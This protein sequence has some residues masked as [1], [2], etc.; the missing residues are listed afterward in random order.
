MTNTPI[1]PSSSGV[2]HVSPSSS[3]AATPVKGSPVQDIAL[4]KLK[5][6][7]VDGPKNLKSKSVS[8]KTKDVGI[9]KKFFNRRFS[10]I[11]ET[12][13]QQAKN[14]KIQI[15]HVEQE[16]NKVEVQTRKVD[17]ARQT[18]S[19]E[20]PTDESIE[21]HMNYF[22]SVPDILEQ[23]KVQLEEL[24]EQ[25][26]TANELA[27]EHV[28]FDD[29]P[30]RILELRTKVEHLEAKLELSHAL[31][32][33]EIAMKDYYLDKSWDNFTKVQDKRAALKEKLQEIFDENDSLTRINDVKQFLGKESWNGSDTYQLIQSAFPS[34]KGQIERLLNCTL[35]MNNEKIE[36]LE[37]KAANLKESISEYHVLSKRINNIEGWLYNDSIFGK[38][39]RI[40]HSPAS[41]K[42]RLQQ[43][44]NEQQ[45]IYQ[46]IKDNAHI[47]SDELMW[48]EKVVQLNPEKASLRKDLQRCAQQLPKIRMMQ[49]MS[50]GMGKIVNQLQIYINA[51]FVDLKKHK[52]IIVDEMQKLAHNVRNQIFLPEDLTDVKV[53]DQVQTVIASSYP[54]LRERTKL[55]F[56]L[57]KEAKLRTELNKAVIAEFAKQ[58]KPLE[59]DTEDSTEEGTEEGGGAPPEA[60]PLTPVPSDTDNDL[61][62]E[63]TKPS[64]GFLAHLK[65]AKLKKGTSKFTGIVKH[66]SDILSQIKQGKGLKKA[67][68]P[69][70]S[71]PQDHPHLAAIKAGVA[72]KKGEAPAT[73]EIP[74]FQRLFKELQEGTRT[75]KDVTKDELAQLT[76]MERSSLGIAALRKN[77]KDDDE[78][79]EDWNE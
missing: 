7:D 9:L 18:I 68:A 72:L 39:Y 64:G 19:E 60:P 10:P 15:G 71:E 38:I 59:I 33:V 77:T 21:M 32:D 78:T 65:N 79:N 63:G 74:L 24:I 62:T 16:L 30:V 47:S 22:D 2:G 61:D 51:D 44:Q 70:K 14:I 8:P 17:K 57:I 20:F 6:K 1:S 48:L 11:T 55:L 23:A 25:E 41:L 5:A 43:A 75:M 67:G 66:A 13:Q 35:E 53:L 52:K 34:L 50:N 3:E 12:E 37:E 49:V 28:S 46:K 36:N 73:K 31:I 76:P 26:Q 40:F 45:E 29:L 42:K 58:P 69:V 27:D 56:Q 4:E 54:R